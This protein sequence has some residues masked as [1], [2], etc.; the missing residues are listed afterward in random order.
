[1]YCSIVCS[2][3]RNLVFCKGCTNF[4]KRI[5]T[6]NVDFLF[7]P[8]QLLWYLVSIIIIYNIIIHY[9][10]CVLNMYNILLYLVLT[11]FNSDL[12]IGQFYVWCAFFVVVYF[13]VLLLGVLIF[14]VYW[15]KILDLHDQNLSELRNHSAILVPPLFLN[16]LL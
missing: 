6:S 12:C 2:L 11:I 3:T 7:K 4:Y 15:D 16:W 5:S 10:W 13:C 9:V 8:T 14:C 1:M